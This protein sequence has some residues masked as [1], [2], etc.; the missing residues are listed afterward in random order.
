MRVIGLMSGTSVDGI[1]AA[2][3]EITG[4]AA[5]P[6]VQLLAGETYEYPVAVRSQILAV[7]GGAPLTMAEL[8]E[9][10]DAIAHAFAHAAMA[11]AQMDDGPV[12]LIGSHGQTVFH[13]P[14]APPHLGYTQQLGRGDL[15]AM[16]TGIATVSNFRAA[17]I[18]LGGQ[19]APLVPPVDVALLSHPTR[20]RAV[21]NIGGIGNVAF[22]PARDRAVAFAGFDTGPGN[23]LLDLA[24]THLSQGEKTYDD[25]GNWASQGTIHA[26]LV[27]QWLTHPYFQQVP[28]KSTGR[29]LFGEAYLQACFATAPDLSA[30][31]MLAN[32]TELTALSIVQSYHQFL[33][34]M[35]QEV[36]VCGGGSRN[37]YLRSRLQFH[38]PQAAVRTTTDVG[39]D[40]DSKEAIAFA[41]LAYWRKQGI[42]GNLPQV[43]GAGAFA[44]LGEIHARGRDS[45][46]LA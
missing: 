25:N 20:D 34:R 30:T 2:L 19:G 10:D 38:L 43:T 33:P 22:L 37:G 15:I 12:D 18:A 35:P 8:A 36:L 3:V 27:Q 11:I 6:Q 28:P 32:L 5:R 29:E 13:R 42:Y 39:V 9:L 7:C 14:P 45:A 41:V 23:V 4:D 26:P 24:V 17:D 44:L 1:D 21:Q 46:V 40:A 16:L 31:D